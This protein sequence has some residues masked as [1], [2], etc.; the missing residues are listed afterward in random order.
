MSVGK[1]GTCADAT[2]LRQ[3]S[4]VAKS[5]DVKSASVRLTVEPIHR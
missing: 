3:A 5:V 2:M 1:L 4:C